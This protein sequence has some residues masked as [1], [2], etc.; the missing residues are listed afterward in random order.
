MRLCVI[1]GTGL[2]LSVIFAGAAPTDEV[3]SEDCDSPAPE[4]HYRQETLD[5]VSK[6]SSK[7]TSNTKTKTKE[8]V[9]VKHLKGGL[10]KTIIVDN[11]SIKTKKSS[12]EDDYNQTNHTLN[13]DGVEDAD[14]LTNKHKHVMKETDS[15][16]DKKTHIII[17]DKNGNIVSDTTNEKKKEKKKKKEKDRSSSKLVHTKKNVG[18]PK[19]CESPPV[20]PAP[21]PDC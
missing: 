4:V 18:I 6:S 1:L 2:I 20:E 15:L 14:S 7:D 8:K 3:P 19:D 21:A 11:T 10:T 17:T 5:T 16:K 9:K 13:V 12:V